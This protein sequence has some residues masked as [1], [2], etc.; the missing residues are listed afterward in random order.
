MKVAGLIFWAL[1]VFTQLT[2]MFG[3]PSSGLGG[4]LIGMGGVLLIVL[5]GVG[6]LFYAMLQE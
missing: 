5:F 1:L 4:D 2:A 3:F 6:G